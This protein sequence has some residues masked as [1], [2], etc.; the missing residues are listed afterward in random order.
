MTGETPSAAQLFVDVLID[1]QFLGMC[2]LLASIAGLALLLRRSPP[3]GGIDFVD[4]E[5]ERDAPLPEWRQQQLAA[6]AV[7]DI[8]ADAPVID[9]DPTRARGSLHL[10][11]A[12][13]PREQFAR[14]LATKAERRRRL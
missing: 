1:P 5:L 6:L 12:P 7:P 10:V 2:L 4:D 9:P 8:W 11:T 3:G 14:L 13:A